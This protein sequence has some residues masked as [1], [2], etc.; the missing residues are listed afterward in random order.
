MAHNPALGRTGARQHGRVWPAVGDCGYG[1]G[2]VHVT[3]GHT[4]AW[5][6]G[7]FLFIYADD[8]V[9]DKGVYLLSRVT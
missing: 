3:V 1:T 6:T 2:N 8:P 5:A 7:G 4:A 9:G